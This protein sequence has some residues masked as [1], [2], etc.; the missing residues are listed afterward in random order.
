MIDLGR[1]A[2]DIL[3]AF[4]VS[5][6]LIGALVAQSVWSARRVRRRLDGEERR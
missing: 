5:L 6:G 2:F 3:L 4:G 1:Y